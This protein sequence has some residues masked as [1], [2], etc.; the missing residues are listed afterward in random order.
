MID[1]AHK[2]VSPSTYSCDLCSLTHGNFGEKDHWTRFREN[3]GVEMRFLY[4]EE[5]EREFGPS[6]KYPFIAKDQLSPELLLN[7]QEI[8]EIESVE[9]L[10]ETLKIITDEK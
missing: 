4:S 5:F 8:S 9:E 10:I 7:H 6:F 2:I 1:F 3:S